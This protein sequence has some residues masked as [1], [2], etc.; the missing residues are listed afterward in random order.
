MSSVQT[1]FLFGSCSSHT[2]LQSYQEWVACLT[3]QPTGNT[4][5]LNLP[6]AMKPVVQSCDWLIVNLNNCYLK[7]LYS[8]TIFLTVYTA[9]AHCM[10]IRLS[11]SMVFS[12]LR[13]CWG[14]DYVRAVLQT[15]QYTDTQTH[16]HTCP[17]RVEL[18][19][20]AT[21]TPPQKKSSLGEINLVSKLFQS[22]LN[23][24]VSS[25]G[26]G[27]QILGVMIWSG[28]DIAKENFDHWRLR[29]L[30]HCFCPGRECTTKRLL[31][32]SAKSSRCCLGAAWLVVGAAS[33]QRRP[34]LKLPDVSMNNWSAT[35]CRDIWSPFLLS[36]PYLTTDLSLALSVCSNRG[37]VCWSRSTSAPPGHLRRFDAEHPGQRSSARWNTDVTHKFAQHL[38]LL[39]ALLVDD[40]EE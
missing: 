20:P 30:L 22:L 18:F 38:A 11:T 34:G 35:F 4:E 24:L 31:P 2:E 14:W 28:R 33:W 39:L 23:C 5:N 13:P 17:N 19:I 8:Q 16:A 27:N 3:L 1:S 9:G 21:P 32:V 10:S 12:V 7:P 40:G 25:G 15:C 6:V 37:S 26:I 36:L 29:H